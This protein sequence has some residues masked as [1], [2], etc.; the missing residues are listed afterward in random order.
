MILGF[1]IFRLDKFECV[2]GGGNWYNPF[3]GCQ[4]DPH[5]L[6]D[7]FWGKI[8]VCDCADIVENGYGRELR[9]VTMM[10]V[11]VNH[12]LPSD[13]ELERLAAVP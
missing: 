6:D 9:M 13:V 3:Y 1:R 10:M 12:L 8:V 11:V 2:S 7:T 5:P 4:H